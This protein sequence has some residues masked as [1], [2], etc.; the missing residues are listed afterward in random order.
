MTTHQAKSAG[1]HD[2]FVEVDVNPGRVLRAIARIGYTPESAI[3]DIVDNAVEAEAN[4][5]A[6]QL[7]REP[8]VAENRRNS[9]ARYVIAD[10]GWG[11]SLDQLLVA[12]G[13]GVDRDYE[14]G[15]L[16]KYGLGLKSAGL[17]QGDRIEI[18]SRRN[19]DD[20]HKV[21]LDL[22]QVESEGRYGCQ[23]LALNDEDK[24]RLEHLLPGAS[25]GTVV[26]IEKMH[27]NNHPSIKKTR[28]ALAARLGFT[29]YYFLTGE[30]R[31]VEI[32]LD[33]ESVAPFDPLF[34]DE[35][36]EAGNLDD[37]TWDGRDVHWLERS[38]KITLDAENGV[39]AT[40]EVT[41]LVHPPSFD[42]PAEI[43]RKYMIGGR[44]YGFYVYR[45][46][47]LIRWGERFGGMVATDQDYYSFRGRI[48]IDDTA[49]DAFNIDVKK[50]EIL[51]SE[52]AYTALDEAT[53]EARRA[54]KSAW[55]HAAW[56]ITEQAN[57]DPVSKAIEALSEVEFPDLLPTDPDDAQAESV[58]KH[59]EYKEAERHP[60][61]DEERDQARKEGSH[62]ALVNHLDDNALWERAHDAS[63][64][65]VVR[66]NKAHRFTRM[67]EERFGRDADVT[68]LV[69][70][71][72]LSFAV[73]ES[74]SVRN[75]QNVE[76]EK[77]E[78]IFR[79]YREMV[80]A[81][82]YKATSDALEQRLV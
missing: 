11:M 69:H 58:R 39:E 55:K 14:E 50:S 41:Q 76:D 32:Q 47:R 56:L 34:I 54:S 27:K 75:I 43:R 65:T 42:N 70:A 79:R 51:L 19:G 35:A 5:V 29:Y 61:R 53:Y 77:L 45:N 18:V 22:Q 8:S 46:K 71:L 33:G 1:T 12:L 81:A 17:S 62:V 28:D 6:I 57:L 30:E 37:D 10:N 67:F 59:R 64:G 9:A 66:I 31:S 23:V 38:R 25:H 13:L 2:Q 60:L 16:G 63:L 4:L 15:S 80:S 48:F 82:V 72:F 68:L 73:G 78:E 24:E 44:H 26:A 20:W 52:E 21:A 36:N 7:E 74:R 3:C 49:D 40:L